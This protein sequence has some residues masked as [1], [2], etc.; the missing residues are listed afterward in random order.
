MVFLITQ[1]VKT[2]F[3][4]MKTTSYHRFTAN[5]FWGGKGACNFLKKCFKNLLQPTQKN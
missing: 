5:N 1:D 4:A 2:S 3:G